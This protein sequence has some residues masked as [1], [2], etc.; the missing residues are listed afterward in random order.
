MIYF[1]AYGAIGILI[2][3]YKKWLVPPT[4]DEEL[5]RIADDCV[6]RS[7]YPDGMPFSDRSAHFIGETIALVVGI[8]CWPVI[9]FNLLRRDKNNPDA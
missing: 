9:A 3:F 2:I 1:I 4:R 5:C 6:K 7:K 8:I